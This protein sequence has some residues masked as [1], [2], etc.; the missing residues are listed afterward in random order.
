MTE[1]QSQSRVA[2]WVISTK[3]RKI[4]VL[5]ID[6]TD[7]MIGCHMIRGIIERVCVQPGGTFA[8]F[9]LVV[10]LEGTEVVKDSVCKQRGRRRFAAAMD[11]WKSE[12]RTA[13]EEKDLEMKATCAVHREKKEILAI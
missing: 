12:Y 6:K 3:K 11:S 2:K 1:K 9:K 8:E 4:N 7:Q 13:F 10:L 5:K